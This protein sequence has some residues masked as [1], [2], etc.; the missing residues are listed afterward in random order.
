[1]YYFEPAL[2]ILCSLAGITLYILWRV[3]ESDTAEPCES[4]SSH[5]RKALATSDFI[6]QTT[7]RC[8]SGE[9]L[10]AFKDVTCTFHGIEAEI[11]WHESAGDR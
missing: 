7:S 2:A 10:H 5:H 3:L 8:R 9:H 4:R 6:I 11:L 1:M